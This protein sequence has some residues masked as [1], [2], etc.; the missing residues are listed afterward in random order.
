MKKDFFNILSKFL[1]KDTVFLK[2][3]VTFVAQKQWAA[4]EGL[5]K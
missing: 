4:F 1:A 3:L 5:K 2:Y